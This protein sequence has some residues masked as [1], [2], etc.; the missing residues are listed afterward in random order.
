MG[1]KLRQTQDAQ[2]AATAKKLEARLALL[3][4]KGIEKR[5]IDRDTLVRKL[6]AHMEAINIRIAAIDANER[7]TAEL[8]AAKAAKAAAPKKD[9]AAKEEKAAEAP[10]EKKE[11]KEKKPKEAAAEGAEKKEKKEKKPKAAKAEAAE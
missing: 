4:S 7:R 1:S 10:K 11:K 8:A 5:Q 6:K 2:K 9:A 3:I